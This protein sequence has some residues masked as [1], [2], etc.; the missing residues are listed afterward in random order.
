MKFELTGDGVVRRTEPW[1][2]EADWLEESIEKWRFM[3]TCIEVGVKIY[4]DGSS[5]TCG[6]CHIYSDRC[7]RCPVGVA[8][9]ES[10][11][12]GT[13][14]EQWAEMMARDEPMSIEIARAEIKFLES[15]RES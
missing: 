12:F 2:E 9:G 15:L 3:E 6:L 1:P 8:T 7:D 5:A 13:P 10:A 14:Y 11:C 4:H